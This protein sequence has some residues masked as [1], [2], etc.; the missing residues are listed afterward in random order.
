MASIR[1]RKDSGLLLIDF[2]Y[3]GQRCREQ[4]LLADT[5]ANRAR[6]KKLAERIERAISQGRLRLRGIFPR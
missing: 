6:L 4:T 1:A 5:I 3:R 2:R